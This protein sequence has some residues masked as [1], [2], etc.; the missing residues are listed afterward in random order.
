VERDFDLLVKDC[1]YAFFA[2]S[3][4][5]GDS[6]TFAVEWQQ[7][8]VE[9]RRGWCFAGGRGSI[10]RSGSRLVGW[11]PDSP[12]DAGQ[13]V[14]EVEVMSKERSVGRVRQRYRLS[15]GTTTGTVQRHRAHD[16]FLWHW[17]GRT[18]RKVVL[19]VGAGFTKRLGEG[20]S[21]T[22]QLYQLESSQC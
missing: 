16:R 4:F 21:V 13:N 14:G 8:S 22:N 9:P 2:R 10:R 1:R 7:I 20:G 15:F 11:T 17:R 5:D 3:P 6:R 19:L 18:E 12:Q